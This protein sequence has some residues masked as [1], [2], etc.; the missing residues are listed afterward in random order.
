MAGM[1]GKPSRGAKMKVA[2]SGSRCLRKAREAGTDEVVLA[3]E[4]EVE[5]K[6]LSTAGAV[7]VKFWDGK[8]HLAEEAFGVVAKKYSEDVKFACVH[9][10]DSKTI[11]RY[12]IRHSP[13]F[14]FFE[15]GREKSRISGITPK[16]ALDVWCEMNK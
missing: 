3:A 16:E 10:K 11:R 2:R 14:V 7:V 15:K 4:N 5:R 12:E 13:T 9:V 8:P 1:K 6:L